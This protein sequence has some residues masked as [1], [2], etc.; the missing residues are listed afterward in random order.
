MLLSLVSVHSCGT[1]GVHVTSCPVRHLDHITS[2]DT[3]QLNS[4]HFYISLLQIVLMF[5][6]DFKFL[7]DVNMPSCYVFIRSLC[8]KRP[9]LL[10]RYLILSC[11]E[12]SILL[13]FLLLLCFFIIWAGR[14]TFELWSNERPICSVH[15]SC[16]V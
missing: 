16:S 15:A 9:A 1:L 3:T 5:K 13:L 4:R 11:I 12:V 2:S 10:Y 7:T 8:Y 6:T 14:W